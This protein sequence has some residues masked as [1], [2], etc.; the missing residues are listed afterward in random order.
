MLGVV[1]DEAGPAE[2]PIDSLPLDMEARLDTWAAA[3]P[4]EYGDGRPHADAVVEGPAGC[5]RPA[6]MPGLLALGRLRA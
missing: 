2:P 6:R 5:C 4:A 1:V 3:E